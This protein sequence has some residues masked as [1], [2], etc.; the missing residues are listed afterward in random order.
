MKLKVRNPLIYLT[1]LMPSGKQ[2]R[3]NCVKFILEALGERYFS[4]STAL[5]VC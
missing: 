5:N 2:N 4:V 3:G 1:I